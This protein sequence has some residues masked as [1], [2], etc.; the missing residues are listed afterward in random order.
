MTGKYVLYTLVLLAVM[1]GGCA[2]QA[3]ETQPVFLQEAS[4]TPEIQDV[5][6]ATAT[7]LPAGSSTVET[8]PSPT[9]TFLSICPSDVL[10]EKDSEYFLLE[11]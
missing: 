9:V 5:Q 8:P 6:S 3:A 4:A 7:Q 11:K 1:A 10:A 2:P